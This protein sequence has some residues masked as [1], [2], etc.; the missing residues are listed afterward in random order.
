[1][2]QNKRNALIALI[3]L[4]YQN[5]DMFSDQEVDQLMQASLQEGVPFKPRT[6]L[7]RIAKIGLLNLADTAAFGLIPDK[8]I[9]KARTGAEKIAAGVGDVAGFAVPFFG[10]GG[11]GAKLGERALARTAEAV[12][13]AEK[14]LSGLLEL[15]GKAGTKAEGLAGRIPG[16]SAE[17]A[18]KV[19]QFFTRGAEKLG[20]ANINKNVIG[21]LSEFLTSEGAVNA[22]RRAGRFGV[23]LGAQNI[24]EKGIDK[25]ISDFFGGVSLGAIGSIIKALPGKNPIINLRNIAR[26]I[27]IQQTGGQGEEAIFNRLVTL[28]STL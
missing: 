18:R 13:T 11:I 23:A 19:G 21:K 6:S 26:L 4:Y 27:A 25:A 7:D 22:A 16:I 24:G 8:F 1:M 9:P 15:L 14:P 5:P 28:A 3:R 17:Q 12:G 20:S 10:L 2:A